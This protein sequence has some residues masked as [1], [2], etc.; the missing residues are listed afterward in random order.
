[1]TA[2]TV[3]YDSEATYVWWRCGTKLRA[4]QRIGKTKSRVVLLAHA[5]PTNTRQRASLFA[6]RYTTTGRIR[7]IT[8]AQKGCWI[9]MYRSG[10]RARWDVGFW[11]WSEADLQAALKENWPSGKETK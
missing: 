6:R 11:L 9:N 5:P 2:R 10:Q 1:M 3:R 8:T 7:K 4:A